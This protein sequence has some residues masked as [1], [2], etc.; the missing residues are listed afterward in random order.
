MGRKGSPTPVELQTKHLTKA[1]KE[2]RK[3]N[4]IQ[5]GDSIFVCPAYVKADKKAYAKWKECIAI[6]DTVKDWKL[7]SSGDTG[8]IARYCITYSEYLDLVERREEI[9]KLEGFSPEEEEMIKAEIQEM[10]GSKVAAKKMWMKVEYILSAQAVLAFDQAI[11]KKLQ[12][13]SQ[14]EDRLFLNPLSKVRNIVQKQKK[15]EKK[16]TPLDKFDL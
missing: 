11:N 12:V 7:V 3:E 2:Y 13:L 5:T 9:A 16:E 4:R 6:F 10:T 14:M 8:L 15:A 1:E